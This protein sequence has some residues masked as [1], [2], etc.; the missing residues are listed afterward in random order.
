MRILH[1]N[2]YKEKIGGAEVYMYA[3]ME[4]LSKRGHHIKLFTS[5]VTEKDY[6]YRI[7]HIC[8]KDYLNRLF[9]VDSYS[10]IK[11]VAT[12]FKP[13]I[14]HVHGIFNE[15]SPSII[16]ALKRYPIVMT[17]H[18]NQI[19]S[20]LPISVGKDGTPCK[21]EVCRGCRNCVGWKGAVF[22][23]IKR[24]IH[25]FL[26]RGIKLYICPSNY[27]CDKLQQNGLRNVFRLANGIKLLEH[28]PIRNFNTILFIG[29]L[30][31]E[32]GVDVLIRAM[33]EV[34]K[35]YPEAHLLIAGEGS[36]K[37]FCIKLV[38]E[39]HLE[40]NIKFLG[41][42][43]QADVNQLYNDV[44]FTVVPSI[45]P[46]NFPTVCLES[47]SAGRP[48]IGSAMGGIPE[49]IEDGKSGCLVEPASYMALA[50]KIVCLLSDI[51]LTE[52]M[53]EYCIH[54]SYEYSLENHVKRLENI[55][56]NNI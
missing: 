25:Q 18:N 3:V 15:L 17:V 50:E 36:E 24:Y 53:S 41:K 19:L 22:E 30:I 27:M 49:M 55:Y 14:V 43:H 54:K 10:R 26:L 7:K 28:K 31:N 21:Q 4:E 9:N 32:K 5:D 29:Q 47:M 13:D 2:D 6:S 8:P 56:K 48:V 40:S 23:Y 45:I 20:P 33:A 11:H 34:V 51:K 38:H 52:K 46:D 44:V 16:F 37:Q 42:I 12:S 39:L 1:I 35:E